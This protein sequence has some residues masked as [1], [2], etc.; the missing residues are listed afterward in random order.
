MRILINGANGFVGRNLAE[1][2]RARYENVF[3]PR[4]TELD[5]CDAGAVRQYFSLNRFD[6]V[7]HCAVTLTSVEQNLKMYFNVECCADAFGKMISVG[8]GGEYDAR[9]YTPMMKEDYFGKHVPTDIYGFSKYVIGKDIEQGHKNIFNL[10]VFGIYGKHE[11]YMR[12]FISNNICR[13][14]AGL[15]LSVKKN[16]RFDYLYVKDFSRI[17]EG[18]MKSEPT[19]KSYNVCTSRPVDLYSLAEMIR[20]IHGKDTKITAQNDGMN[21]EYSGDNSRFLQEFGSVQFTEHKNAI[22]ELYDW[23]RND[24][25]IQFSQISLD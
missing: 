22:S 23:Y 2:F 19:H 13:V 17:L 8:S 16:S 14:L 11:N 9:H 24:S 21:P 6:I 25:Q 10:R 1:Y 5:L 12:R 4:R 15:D 3:T 20:A 18:F 7:I